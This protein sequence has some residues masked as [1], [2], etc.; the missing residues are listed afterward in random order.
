MPISEQTYLKALCQTDKIL[1]KIKGDRT[2][3]REI[4]T[5]VV[6]PHAAGNIIFGA[7]AQPAQGILVGN[8]GEVLAC[9]RE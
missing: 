9:E 6:N 4:P 1:F 3:D 2:N 8:V 7:V 5:H